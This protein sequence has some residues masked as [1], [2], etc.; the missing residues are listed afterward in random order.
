M[1]IR[2][3]KRI[4]AAA[5]T[6][7][8]ITLPVGPAAAAEGDDPVLVGAGDIS[9][10]YS[11]GDQATAELLENIDGQI[12]STG[13]SNQS[14]GSYTEYMNCFDK[15]WGKFKDRI[16]PVPGNHDYTEGFF[17]YWGDKVPKPEAYY[18]YELG[19]WQV[20]AL[21]SMLCSQMGGC[22]K[23]EAWLRNVLATSTKQCT[24]AYWHY[25]YFTSGPNYS[26]SYELKGFV[27]A[28]Y[29][30]GAEII[31]SGHNH[32][33]ERFAPQ[34]PNF[35]SDPEFGIRQFV[36]GTGG[37]SHYHFGYY[38]KPSSEAWNDDTFGVLKLTLKSGS[39]DWEFIPEAGETFTD[40]GTGTCH[41]K[42]TAT[43]PGPTFPPYPGTR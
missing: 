18:T 43:P 30:A 22:Q 4:A 9:S 20:I 15:T 16:R 17:K 19:D 1:R 36:V 21:N 29:Q 28:L 10:C 2:K 33:Y 27:D 32:V 12:F 41:G 38:T 7:A 26:P 23:E 3:I 39:Y 24:I 25:P 42:P 37:A 11:T 40:K 6:A 13:D 8:A 14:S 34:N 31:M 5:I 35:K